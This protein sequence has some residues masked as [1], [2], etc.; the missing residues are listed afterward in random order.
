MIVNVSYFV[1][2]HLSTFFFILILNFAFF[3]PIL[4][5]WIS[6]FRFLI[7][8]VRGHYGLMFLMSQDCDQGPS[9]LILAKLFL[10]EMFKRE[11]KVGQPVKYP[12]PPISRFIN[13][14]KCCQKQTAGMSWD[15]IGQSGQ[16]SLC[17]LSLSVS[18]DMA[19][20]LDVSSQPGGVVWPAVNQGIPRR[21]PLGCSWPLRTRRLATGL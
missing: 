9:I 13:R 14:N 4:T 8:K 12:P 21:T 17:C 3:L 19:A 5:N 16:Y 11:Q 6:Q 18:T 1:D 2:F 15:Y 10:T 20:M 7:H